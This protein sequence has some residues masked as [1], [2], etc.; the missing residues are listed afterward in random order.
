MKNLV[1]S[2]LGVILLAASFWSSAIAQDNGKSASGADAAEKFRMLQNAPATALDVGLI[3]LRQRIMVSFLANKPE[4]FHRDRFKFLDVVFF[5]ESNSIHI[6][7]SYQAEKATQDELAADCRDDIDLVMSLLTLRRPDG[8]LFG[9]PT[10]SRNICIV[11]SFNVDRS[12]P[13]ASGMIDV[14]QSIHIWFGVKAADG[15]TRATCSR[16]FGDKETLVRFD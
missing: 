6:E 14:C 3:D 1:G 2:Y 9:S 13:A 8:E 10:E 7:G 12:A 11:T 5:P 15:K 16:A 4:I